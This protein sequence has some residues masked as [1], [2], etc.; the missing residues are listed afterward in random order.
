MGENFSD[1]VSNEGLVSR[2][3]KQLMMLNSIKT[4]NS[5]KKWPE[6]LNKHFSKEDIQMAKRHMKR[7]S[8]SLIKIANQNY[9]EVPLHDSQNA[10]H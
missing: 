9:N 4:K 5:L 2:I 10:H 6:D 7:W 1:D 8:T 3:Y